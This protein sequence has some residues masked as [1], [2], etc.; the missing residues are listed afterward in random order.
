MN[1]STVR[2]LKS[3]V[4]SVLTRARGSGVG[5]SAAGHDAGSD[6]GDERVLAE[7]ALAGDVVLREAL[8]LRLC[9]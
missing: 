3:E 2:K 8:G 7:G 4:R 1:V 6:D 5:G 9:Q